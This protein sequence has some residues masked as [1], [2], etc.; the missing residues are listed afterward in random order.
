M[1]GYQSADHDAVT[2]TS[3]PSDPVRE[4]SDVPSVLNAAGPEGRRPIYSTTASASI[5]TSRPVG[6]PT[7]TVVRAG[8][9]FVT[10]SA[11]NSP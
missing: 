10:C 8:Y 11:M 7:Y 4:L 3:R 9:G 2:P 6:R 5:S 1:P